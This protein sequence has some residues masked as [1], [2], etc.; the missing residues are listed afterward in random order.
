[1]ESVKKEIEVMAKKLDDLVMK[2]AAKA[3]D[4]RRYPYYET[5]DKLDRCGI[6][7]NAARTKLAKARNELC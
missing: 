4:F 2:I 6:Y 1:M 3:S 7:V 5:G